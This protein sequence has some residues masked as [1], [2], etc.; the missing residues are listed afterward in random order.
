M[1][2]RLL[3][4]ATGILAFALGVVELLQPGLAPL[5]RSDV[6]L[7]T[8]AVV[9]LVYAVVV[10]YG[11]RRRRFDRV[12]TPDVEL[13][14]PPELPGT[15]L[16]QTL[17][18]FPATEVYDADLPTV[19][20]ELRSV[21]VSVLTRY[22]GLDP[23]QAAEQ[24]ETGT[25]TEDPHA[26]AYLAVTE[27]DPPLQHR[28]RAGLS[29]T[30]YA[31]YARTR[32]VDA[33]AGAA[34]VQTADLPPWEERQPEPVDATGTTGRQPDSAGDS[35]G[36]P[37][38]THHWTG[39]SVV[40]LVCLGVGVL[41]EQPGVVLAGAVAV[42]YATYARATPLG[43]VELSAS[44][45]LSDTDPDPGDDL[46]VTVTVTN[47]GGFCPDLRLVDGVPASL[48]VVDG[49]PRRGTALRAGESVTFSYTLRVSQGTHEFGPTQAVVHNLPGSTEQ[50]L[51]VGEETTV[52]AIPSPRPVRESVPLRRQPTQ[53]AGRAPTDSG[54][55]GIEFHTVREYQ[56]GDS[57][58]RI[59]WNRRARTGEMTTLEFRQERAT[60]V[61][62]LVD[63]RLRSYVGHHPLAD[64]AVERSVAA[65]QRLFP[66]LLDDGHQA[67]I[68]AFGPRECFLAPDTGTSHRQRGRELLATDSAFHDQTEPDGNRRFWVPQ[69]RRQ[70]PDNA[71]LLLFSPLADERTARI[72][73]EFEA[74]GYPTTVISPD[75][76]TRTTPSHRLMRARRRV[77]MTDLRQ[78]GVP[79]L[80]WAPGQ[81]LEQVLKREVATR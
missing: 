8:L 62:V 81:T 51:L 78:T 69:L 13:A 53:Y 50:E 29:L 7:S 47:E 71:Q 46:T 35:R 37:R 22:R 34:G 42:G 40:V 18:L 60:R 73:R 76:T 64:D 19:R 2:W 41:L 30:P 14:T 6:L 4:A 49:V 58:T 55:E 27:L 63:T 10:V 74:Y 45:E 66:A 20:A 54:G 44:R 39:V 52:T 67:G 65:A 33:V 36:E 24:V 16:D 28:L 43:V 23:E 5:P 32:A 61:V 77:L 59:D 12:E 31:E 26:A 70:L 68:A 25:W 75:P 80:D 79:V 21:A 11:R 38:A 3:F 17:E 1:N 48:A 56:P 57:M 9:G 72:V 15:S